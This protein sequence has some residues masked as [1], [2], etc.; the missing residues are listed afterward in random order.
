MGFEHPKQYLK[1]ANQYVIDHATATFCSSEYIHKIIVCL[2]PL[3]IDQYFAKT[4]LSQNPKV[5]SC[6]GGVSR[7]DSVWKAMKNIQASADSDDWVFIHDACRP[8]FG[9]VELDRL[10]KL[11][12]D[13]VG[14]ILALPASD[15]LKRADSSQCVQSTVQRQNLWRAL[16]PQIFRY[17]CL[18]NA[19]EMSIDKEDEIEDEAMAMQLAGYSVPLIRGEASNIKLTYPTDLLFAESYLRLV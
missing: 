1:I 19:L 14:G 10:M 18:F 13:R 3:D 16:T 11:K 15:A 17:N 12:D 5:I 8:C 2:N 4:Q 9:Q 6:L 7:A